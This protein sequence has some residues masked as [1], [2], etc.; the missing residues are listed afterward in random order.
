MWPAGPLT[1]RDATQNDD[2]KSGERQGGLHGSCLAGRQ[3][4]GGLPPAVSRKEHRRK[5]GKTANRTVMHSLCGV[6]ALP[7]LPESTTG[8]PSSSLAPK[9]KPPPHR[10]PVHSSTGLPGLYSVLR[11]RFFRG[12]GLEDIVL[13]AS[14]RHSPTSLASTLQRACSQATC[15][16]LK[17]GRV[18]R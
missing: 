12:Q 14:R 7:S 8:T 2:S 15:A 4:L 6:P 5:R 17:P 16:A 11:T 13:L 3:A 18:C 10:I 9:S 1:R